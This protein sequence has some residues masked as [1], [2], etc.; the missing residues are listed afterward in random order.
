M[1]AVAML[2]LAAGGSLAMGQ[3]TVATQQY[4]R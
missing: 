4:P 1:T 2:A 3:T